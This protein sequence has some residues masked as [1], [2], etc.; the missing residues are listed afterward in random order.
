M[1]VRWKQAPF[2][3]MLMFLTLVLTV[4][5]KPETPPARA[6]QTEALASPVN[7]PLSVIAILPTS[8][9]PLP[10]PPPWAITPGPTATYTPPPD[11]QTFYENESRYSLK[12]STGWYAYNAHGGYDSITNYD[13]NMVTDLNKFQPGDLKINIGVGKLSIGQSFQQWVS[14]RLTTSTS[15]DPNYPVPSPTATTP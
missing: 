7:P 1:V 4:S 15:P 5:C 6:P 12:L 10:T 14:N 13:V 11:K 3:V 2:A 8:V 9:S